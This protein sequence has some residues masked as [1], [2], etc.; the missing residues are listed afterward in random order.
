MSPEKMGSSPKEMGMKP[1]QQDSKEYRGEG[2]PAGLHIYVGY[3]NNN[4]VIRFP[5]VDI[6]YKLE[7]AP[8]P[9]VAEQ[10]FDFA[11][12]TALQVGGDAYEV[13]KKVKDFS[14]NLSSDDKDKE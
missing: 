12:K 10:I 3:E 7:G 14:H 6:T 8:D 1:E 4:Y 2:K 9:N 13:L 11:F 5:Q